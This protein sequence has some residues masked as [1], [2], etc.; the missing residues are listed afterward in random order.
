MVEALGLGARTV[1]RVR[2]RFVLEGF[3]A[4]LNPRPQPKRPD[5]VIVKG[6]VEDKLVELACSD[7][8][9]GRCQWTLQLLADE[10]VAL[11]YVEEISYETVRQALK[12]RHP[13]LGGEDVVHPARAGRRVRVLHGGCPGNLSAALQP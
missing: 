9:S 11:G 12:K 5:K 7:P 2:K 4:A 8:P 13:A 1:E 10:L 3:D 6:L